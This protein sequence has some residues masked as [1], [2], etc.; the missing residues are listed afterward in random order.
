[1]RRYLKGK[2]YMIFRLL[3]EN[4]IVNKI[5]FENGTGDNLFFGKNISIC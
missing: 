3:E 5:F 4:N 2:N 1:M